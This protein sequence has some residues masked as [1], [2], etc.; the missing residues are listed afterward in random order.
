MGNKMQGM[1]KKLEGL[2]IH[3][4]YYRTVRGDGNCF[5]R[6]FMYSYLE[7]LVI[8]GEDKLDALVELYVV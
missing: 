4:G 3:Y 8:L 1:T 2:Q 7:L 5:Y 6:S